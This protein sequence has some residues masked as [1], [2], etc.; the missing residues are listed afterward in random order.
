MAPEYYSIYIKLNPSPQMFIIK[1]KLD[2]IVVT[3]VQSIRNSEEL[4]LF[5]P[6]GVSQVSA[7]QNLSKGFDRSRRD[8]WN[9]G[10]RTWESESRF[11]PSLALCQP[12]TSRRISPCLNCPLVEWNEHQ[13]FTPQ[14]LHKD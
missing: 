13:R 2:K 1:A 8:S 7:S 6:L 10:A 5:L 11:C 14:G 12:E 3:G 9:W 4:V